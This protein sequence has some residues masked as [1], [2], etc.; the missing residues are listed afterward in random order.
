MINGPSFPFC[1]Q[2]KSLSHTYFWELSNS[3]HK[4]NTVYKLKSHQFQSV[5][6]ELSCIVG[7]IRTES[8]SC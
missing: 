7:R 1:I 5:I 2:L 4:W 6:S 3:I 8:I